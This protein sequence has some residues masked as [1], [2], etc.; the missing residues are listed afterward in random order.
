MMLLTAKILSG[1][2]LDFI[3]GDP[4]R[5]PHPVRFIGMAIEKLEAILRKLNNERLAGIVLLFVISS[6]V[7]IA[8]MYLAGISWAIEIFLIYTIFAARSL[9]LEGMKIYKLLAADNIDEARK[10]VSFLVSRD[11]ENMD[12]REI[13]R[14]AVETIAENIVDGVTAPMFYLFTGGAPLA[15]AYKSVNTLDSMVGYKNDKYIRF[16]WASARFDDALNF[17][18]AR[19]TGFILIPAAAFITGGSL[20]GSY[21]VLLRD[22]YNHS[23]PNSGHPES[24]SAG[25]LGI[26]LGGPTSYFGRLHEKPY[27]GDYTRE[28]EP[29]D[30]RRCVKLMYVTSLLGLLLGGA[31]VIVLSLII[32]QGSLF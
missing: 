11:T 25:A 1:F 28:L 9:S 30:I 26:R 12:R 18:P 22:R 8:T 27:I 23:S 24:A 19:I 21:R 31:V 7:Y 13:I 29:E 17:I 10:Q 3:L 16:G 15:M 6:S 2:A 32:K 20:S 5:F 4:Y 14:A